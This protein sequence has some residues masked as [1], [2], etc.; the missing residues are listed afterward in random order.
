MNAARRVE[1]RIR[2]EVERRS[3]QNIIAEKRGTS[4][5]GGVVVM[6]AHY[7][8]VPK[9]QGAGDNGTGV[10][11]LVL[12]AHELADAEFPFTVRFIFF[13][14]EEIGL[15]GSRH[16]VESLSAAE[17]RDIVVMKNFDAM[18]AGKGVY[19]RGWGAG[20]RRASYSRREWAKRGRVR[21]NARGRQRSCAVPDAGVRSCSF[22]GDDFS[23][24]NSPDD[25]LRFVDA[26]IMGTHMTVALRL[27][28]EIAS[29]GR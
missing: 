18:G 1:A 17:L 2:V 8:S 26:S 13:G 7:D 21:G 4:A 20:E 29:D 11:A 12:M 24:I 23:R 15:R 27:L 5:D 28:Y 16:Y 6:G 25:E 14:V 19:P 9:S 22:S 3:S 10:A